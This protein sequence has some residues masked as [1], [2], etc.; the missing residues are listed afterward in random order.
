MD[1]FARK[2]M[3]MDGLG[4]VGLGRADVISWNMNHKETQQPTRQWGSRLYQECTVCT[5]FI[6]AYLILIYYSVMTF[7][8]RRVR[9][10]PSGPWNSSKESN[11]C[12]FVELDRALRCSFISEWFSI[13]L[14]GWL[15]VAGEIPFSFW[16]HA[17]ASR[18]GV[19]LSVSGSRDV[20]HNWILIDLT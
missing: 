15:Q 4:L 7:K 8:L 6:N 20:M 16:I 1:G 9:W 19:V 17:K 18:P 12:A 11:T 5:Y 14:D 2:M 13:K 10:V 3:S